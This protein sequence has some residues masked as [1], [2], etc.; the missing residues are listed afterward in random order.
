MRS[1]RGILSNLLH[2]ETITFDITST[3][4]GLFVFKDTNDNYYRGDSVGKG[5]IELTLNT[6][7]AGENGIKIIETNAL[8]EVQSE[9]LIQ[10][11]TSGQDTHMSVD[12]RV[13]EELYILL[14][15]R[16]EESGFTGGAGVIMDINTGEI[17]ALSSFPE[18]NSSSLTEGGI[19]TV[20]G[21]ISDEDKPFLNRAISGLYTP[22]SIIK[23]FLAVAALEEGIISPEKGILSTGSLSIPNPFFPDKPSVF[24]D[25][26]AHGVVDMRQALAVSSNVYFYEIGGGYGDQEGLGID[27]I[28]KY[29]RMFGFG[30]E[31]GIVLS[32]EGIGT[33]PNP[34]WKEQTFEDGIWRVGDTYHTSIGQ[35][36]FQVTLIQTVRAIAAI[37]NGG[38]LLTPSLI[39]KENGS[40]TQ[41]PFNDKNIQVVRE[42]MRLSVTEGTAGGLSMSQVKIAAKTGTAELGISKDF[43]NSWVVGFFPYEKPKYA[44]AVL[45]EHGPR[46]NLIGALYVMR[47]LVEWMNI[48]ASEYVE[49]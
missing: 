25:W 34:E 43:V 36:G 32:G 22:G 16:A 7:L 42:G 49:I 47:Q 27:R 21:Y 19:E 2:K 18:Y 15:E 8:G 23:P 35:Y 26:K 4:K 40:G 41:L 44:F 13:S 48:N 20:Q 14:G 45:M 38:N 17:I 29:T 33:I 9:S 46:E 6:N 39:S 3:D 31:T 30:E 28:E 5:G 11:P 10:K 37:A 12:S 24:K 1:V